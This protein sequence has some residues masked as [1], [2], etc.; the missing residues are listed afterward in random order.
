M[1]APAISAAVETKRHVGGLYNCHIRASY[2]FNT[3]YGL[4]CSQPD[5]IQCKDILHIAQAALRRRNSIQAIIALFP[6]IYGYGTNI[7]KIGHIYCVHFGER[8]L[9]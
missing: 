9:N 2:S 6:Y 1:I 3:S 5:T 8:H 7:A 4:L